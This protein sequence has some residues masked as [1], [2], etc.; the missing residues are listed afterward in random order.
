VPLW[1][2]DLAGSAQLAGDA[3]LLAEL[4]GARID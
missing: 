3:L 2:N 4:I 1:M